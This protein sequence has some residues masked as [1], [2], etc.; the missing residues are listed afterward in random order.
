MS[1]IQPLTGRGLAWLERKQKVNR[2]FAKFRLL[3]MPEALPMRCLGSTKP[4]E[5][6][7][8]DWREEMQRKY[9]VRYFLQETLTA[10]LRYHIAGRL[11]R[12]YWWVR[13]RTFS[14]YHVLDV[15]DRANGYHRG[16]IDPRELLVYAN[17]KV[18]TDFVEKEMGGNL[19]DDSDME[20]WDAAYKEMRELYQWW[21]IDRPAAWKEY[22]EYE[23]PRPWTK[24]DLNSWDE[25]ENRLDEKDDEMIKRLVDIRGFLWS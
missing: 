8:E 21:T 14:R 7:W 22:N 2:F 25:W 10:W 3:K 11:K 5:Y 15:S 4:G 13:Y 18:L 24:D 23:I 19:P 17:F 9:P 1:N 12:V 20:N 16:Y 6:T